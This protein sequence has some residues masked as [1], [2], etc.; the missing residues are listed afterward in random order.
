[1]PVKSKAQFRKF[2]AMFKR[3]EISKATLDE[4][5]KG[6]DFKRLPERV[7]KKRTKRKARKKRIKKTK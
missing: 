4:W 1:M 6:A 7:A 3:G 5:L 2:Q